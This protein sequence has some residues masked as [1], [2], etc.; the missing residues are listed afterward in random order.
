MAEHSFEGTAAL[1]LDGKGRLAMPARHREVLSALQ[2]ETITL[3]KG[4]SEGSLMV[5][6]KPAWQQFRQ[7]L[8]ALPMEAVGW[9]RMFLGSASTVEL[10]GS[11]RFLISPEL[12]AAAG[13]TRDVLLM[14]LGSYFELWDAQRYAVSEAQL[15][16]TPM[17]ESLKNLSFAPA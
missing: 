15:R 13:L 11:S 12:R 2:A 3:T 17:P 16:Q 1:T 4:M 14:G 8:E 5:F 9:K 7:R 10:D 6:P